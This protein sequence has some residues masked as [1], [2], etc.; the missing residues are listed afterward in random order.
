MSIV[1]LHKCDKALLNTPSLS[2]ESS[3]FVFPYGLSESDLQLWAMKYVD[4]DPWVRAALE[5]DLFQHRLECL[6]VQRERP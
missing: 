2:S 1:E 5:K 4:H 3:G 6:H